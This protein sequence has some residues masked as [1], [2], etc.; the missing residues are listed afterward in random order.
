MTNLVIIAAPPHLANLHAQMR[1]LMSHAKA[2][3]TSR[4]QNSMLKS[5]FRYMQFA[6]IPRLPVGGWHLAAYATQLVADGR[7][8]SADTLANYVSAV[9]SYH[10]ELGLDCPTPSQFGP[11][12]QVISGLR[13]LAQRPIKRSLPV[14]PK[15]LVNL[16]QTL[17][18]PPFC[19][20]QTNILITYKILSLFYMLT[21]LR[22]SS[23]LPESYNKVDT[24]RLVTWGNVRYIHHEGVPG[25]CIELH[26]TKTI[27]NGERIQQVPLAANPDSPIL[28]PV[29]AI[30]VLRSMVGEENITADTPLFQTRDYHGNLRPILR[31]KFNDWFRFRLKEMGEIPEKYT[32]HAFRH[33]GVHQMLMSENNLALAKITSDHSSDVILE[34]SQV[35]ADRR[36]VISQ[37]INRNLNC[38]LHGESFIHTLAQTPLPVGVLHRA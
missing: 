6:Q 11:L 16:L 32:L 34:Y 1:F 38:Y 24:L 3:S 9:R 28:C 4:T 23:F 37:K 15:I 21:M 18:P 2:K 29:R 27:Q 12:A 7:V 17:F 20:F 26:R 10:T 8:K 30:A 25:I 13:R 33:G 14:T 35:P 22:A 36:L 31:H 19:P 5:W